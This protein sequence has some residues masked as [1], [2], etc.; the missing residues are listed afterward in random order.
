MIII[1][2]FFNGRK[3]RSVFICLKIMEKRFFFFLFFFIFF[4]F[5]YIY[6]EKSFT[7][8][9]NLCNHELKQVQTQ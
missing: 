6:K 8:N 9:L 3:I 7:H 2:K 1:K 5:L 4:I